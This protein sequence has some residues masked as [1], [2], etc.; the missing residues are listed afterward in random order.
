MFLFLYLMYSSDGLVFH[1]QSV[2]SYFFSPFFPG[3]VSHFNLTA[4]AFA[5]SDVFSTT[6]DNTPHRMLLQGKIGVLTGEDKRGKWRE[7]YVY[8]AQELGLVAVVVWTTWSPDHFLEIGS[9]DFTAMR[10]P[11]VSLKLSDMRSIQAMVE[12]GNSSMSLNSEDSPNQWTIMFQSLYFTVL[13]KAGLGSVSVALVLA[14]MHRLYLWYAHYS[15]ARSFSKI[16][17]LCLSVE[18]VI[19]VERAVYFSLGG[20]GGYP[21]RPFPLVRILYTASLPLTYLTTALT[22]AYLHEVLT[23][24]APL[25]TFVQNTRKPLLALTLFFLLT[26]WPVSVLSALQI[27]SSAVL[28]DISAGLLTA[29]MALTALLLIYITCK[30]QKYFND[31]ERKA[32]ERRGS[33]LSVTQRRTSLISSSSSPSI[34]PVWGGPPADQMKTLITRIQFSLFALLFSVTGM[35]LTLSPVFHNALGF[36]CVN[37]II[38]VGLAATSLLHI[39]AY[40]RT[41]PLTKNQKY[42]PAP[43]ISRSRRKTSV[44]HSAGRLSTGSVEGHSPFDHHSPGSPLAAVEEAPHIHEVPEV[45]PLRGEDEDDS[46]RPLQLVVP[47]GERD[48]AIVIDYFKHLHDDE[49]PQDFEFSDS[50]SDDDDDEGEEQEEEE[51]KQKKKGERKEGSDKKRTEKREAER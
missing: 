33:Q 27:G 51:Q 15:F 11:C 3:G 35:I 43:I 21:R 37:G 7:D 34:S 42:H 48:S 22:T 17:V 45:E 50:S 2:N 36:L 38:F 47:F 6:W 1:Y 40:G 12:T 5:I 9:T 29:G 41:P 30:L 32:T 49:P 13:F 25:G 24:K 19:N 28:V 39:L 16:A 23:S 4:P 8:R 18:L 44:P 31:K 46:D 10:I 26:D 20:L 14:A